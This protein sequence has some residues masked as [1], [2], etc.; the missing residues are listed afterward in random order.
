MEISIIKN[1]EEYRAMCRRLD[2]FLDSHADELNNLNDKDEEELKLISLVIGEWEDAHYRIPD[3]DPIDFIRFMMEQ[4]GLKVRDL[5]PCFGTTSRAYEVLNRKRSLTLGMI[6]RLR[7]A[8]GC[9]A[10]A[11]IEA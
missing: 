6:R 5:A 11:L 2:E 8:L 7:V 4:K 1:D 10:D 3:P 9:S